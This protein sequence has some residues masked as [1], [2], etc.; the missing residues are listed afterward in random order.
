MKVAIHQPLYL[1]WLGY[2]DKMAKVDKFIILDD[3]AFTRP[4]PITRNRF[5]TENGKDKYLTVGI[6]NKNHMNLK[7][8]DIRINLNDSL[9]S[10]ERHKNFL[11]SNYR[12]SPYFNEVW[13]YIEPILSN[14]EELLMELLN[15]TIKFFCDIFEIETQFIYQSELDYDESLKNNDLLIA[16]L[17][18]IGSKTYLSG[19]GAKNYM[20]EALFEES[21]ISIY[22][23]AYE[24][25]I[26]PQFNT[27]EFISNL[28][29]LDLLFNCGFR[30]SRETF[31]ENVKRVDEFLY[32]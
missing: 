21:G 8:S 27:T 30:E 6:H 20:D 5:L 7:I 4:S 28:S 29:S 26:Y 18:A 22:Y 1:P 23:Q 15:N 24:P 9:N 3:V 19:I 14:K 12:K 17:N 13:P 10:L 25:I 16:L 32:L 31:W 11:L 2:L